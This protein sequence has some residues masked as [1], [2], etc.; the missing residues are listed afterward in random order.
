MLPEVS[1]GMIET[2]HIITP[3]RSFCKKATFYEAEV[4]SIDL[5]SKKIFLNYSIGR[6]SQPVA[7]KRNTLD[8]DFLVIALGSENNFFGMSDIET[9]SFTMK[10]IDD[11]ISLRNHVINVT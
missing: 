3:V 7:W 10:D 1:T 9:H 4:E 11:A 8:Y 5:E 2:R 6:Q